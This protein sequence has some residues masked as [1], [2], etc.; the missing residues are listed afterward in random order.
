ML[1]AGIARRSRLMGAPKH[2]PSHALVSLFCRFLRDCIGA[3]KKCKLEPS[4]APH[5]CL[6]SRAQKSVRKAGND[7]QPV[8]KAYAT[9]AQAAYSVQVRQALPTLLTLRILNS[10]W[11]SSSFCRS[12]K[13]SSND[14]SRVGGAC[15]RYE[16][17]CQAIAGW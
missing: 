12:T 11:C 16:R 8:S 6:R 5:E 9:L 2:L 10:N 13:A 1:S 14:R 17:R 7:L 3:R 15:F 4:L